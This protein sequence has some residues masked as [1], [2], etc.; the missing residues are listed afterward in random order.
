MV[1]YDSPSSNQASAVAAG[2]FNP[3]TG[4]YL[5]RTWEADSIF[6]FLEKFYTSAA[7]VLQQ[8]FFHSLPIFIP[9]SSVDERSLWKRKNNSDELKS[10][11][12]AFHETPA[13]AGQVNNPLGGVEVAHSGY[14]RVQCW[15]ETVRKFLIERNAYR[16]EVVDE[17]EIA[18]HDGVLYG[19]LQAD[20][21]IFCNGVSA[22]S[23][24][25]FRKLP[26][27]PLKGEVLSVRISTRMECIFN[28][29]VYVVPGSTED[30]YNIGSTYD[31]P[32]FDDGVTAE[33]RENLQLKLLEL[34]PCPFEIVH[35]DWGIRPTTIDRKPI[36]GSHPDNKNIIL[37]NGLGTKGVSLAPYFSHHLADWLEGRVELMREVNIS[38]FKALYSG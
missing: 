36:L 6:P 25:W 12:K 29:G 27:I 11:I 33:G 23:G 14:L 17:T 28:R 10:Y 19:G 24:R 2:L 3:V 38:R 8:N 18:F 35:Q 31:R 21:I 20:K 5:V 30:I 15:T 26:I 22:L 32:P 13:F 16:E 1:V 7:H 37:F 9:F 34:T 4:K